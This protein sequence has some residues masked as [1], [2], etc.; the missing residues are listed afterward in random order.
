[1]CAVAGLDDTDAVALKLTVNSVYR[2]PRAG[3]V[4][5]VATSAAMTHRIPKVVQVARWLE[6]E[7]VPAVRLLP[8][9]P[10][11]VAA[12]GAQAT[13]WVDAG[14]GA[15]PAPTAAELGAALRGLHAL[16]PPRPALPRWDPLDDVRRRM[17]DAEALP[18]A[19]RVFLEELV[20]RVEAGLRTVRYQLP[21]AV[22]HGDAHLGNLIR[23]P[24]GQVVLCDFDSVSI[25]P[26]E[27]DLIPLAVG[28][29]RFAYPPGSHTQLA[30][31]Y[32]V[33]VTRWDGWPVLR[34]VRELKLVTSVLPIL[35][36]NPTAAAQFRVRLQSL[37]TGDRTVR[38]RPYG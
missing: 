22:I 31:A 26:A 24:D 15:P 27:W 2:L 29:T 28:A 30:A 12:G 9:V 32:G 4:V 13:I 6:D 14:P 17:S 11:P 34:A 7:G 20:G 25:G 3:A 1:M 16:A 33:D 21:T 37:R 19:D 5:R 18:A 38:W 8:A 10:A 23:R 36:S 35:S